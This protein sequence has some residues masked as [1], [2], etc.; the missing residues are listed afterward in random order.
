MIKYN[1]NMK[2]RIKINI[3]NYKEY[4]EKFSSIEIEI[5]LVNKKHGK[6][7]NINKEVE[8]YYHIYF[9]NN[10]DEIKRNFINKN[11]EIEIIKVII[12]YQV[13]S[14]ENLF[15]YCECIESIYFKKF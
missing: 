4:S 13:K 10:I 15:F 7:I 1:K 5:K 3:N 6:F 12:N 14:F 2:K 11:E 9:N 8:K